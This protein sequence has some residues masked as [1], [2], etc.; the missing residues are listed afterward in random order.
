MPTATTTPHVVRRHQPTTVLLPPLRV[1]DE[2][3][4]QPV[5]LHVFH[6]AGNWSALY[7]DDNLAAFGDDYVVTEALEAA[8]TRVHDSGQDGDDFLRGGDSAADVAPT[9]TDIVAYRQERDAAERDAA[10]LEEQARELLERAT[11]LRNRHKAVR[12]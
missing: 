10:A 1:I 2:D 5:V 9:M 12:A 6:S 11:A 4:G 7:C 3:T 8:L